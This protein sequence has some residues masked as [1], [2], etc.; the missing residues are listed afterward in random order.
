[1]SSY[2]K[3]VLLKT[4][5]YLEK[6]FAQ[7]LHT[8]FLSQNGRLRINFELGEILV[9]GISAEKNRRDISF[10]PALFRIRNKMIRYQG[11]IIHQLVPKVKLMSMPKWARP[12]KTIN[13]KHRSRNNISRYKI[14]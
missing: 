13:I 3:A 6:G 4:Q 10:A 2:K 7:F 9:R 1:M 8:C 14:R 5:S 11:S 12:V